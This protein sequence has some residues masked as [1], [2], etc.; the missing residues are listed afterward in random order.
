MRISLTSLMHSV[1]TTGASIMKIRDGRIWYL[2]DYYD[3]DA[4]EAM[5]RSVL[6]QSHCL[7]SS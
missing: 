3:S 1:S 2:G 7:S 6:K 5:L 4:L